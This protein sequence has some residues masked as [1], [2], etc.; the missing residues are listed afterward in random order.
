LLVIEIIC[1]KY[2]FKEIHKRKFK[3]EKRLLSNS[4][5]KGLGIIFIEN[6]PARYKKKPFHKNVY[7]D[8][9]KIQASGAKKSA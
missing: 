2:L 5:Q 6:M 4:G 8:L 3:F 1:I 7:L 9:L